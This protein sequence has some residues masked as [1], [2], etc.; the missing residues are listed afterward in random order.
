MLKKQVVF[1]D[2]V[3]RPRRDVIIAELRRQ[4]A[5]IYWKNNCSF[6]FFARSKC[7]KRQEFYA[8][9]ILVVASSFANRLTRKFEEP[10]WITNTNR[11]FS[12][13]RPQSE[14]WRQLPLWKREH[15]ASAHRFSAPE[16]LILVWQ[17]N[18]LRLRA[19]DF[20]LEGR[21]N[22]R[23]GLWID[24]SIDEST[25]FEWKN[26]PIFQDGKIFILFFTCQAAGSVRLSRDV[27]LCLQF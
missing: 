4:V 24:E 23:Q 3:C 14:K 26:E 8:T 11:P 13:L 19:N 6:F 25:F 21:E 2:K 7:S 18:L 22:R 5:P 10:K 27:S 17:E 16:Q 1:S 9:L 15:K 12:I 20:L